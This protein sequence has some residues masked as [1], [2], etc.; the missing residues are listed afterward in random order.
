[1]TQKETV[2]ALL[3]NWLS[4][5]D[6]L[7]KGGGMRLAAVVHQLKKEGHDIESKWNFS[8]EFVIYRL[9]PKQE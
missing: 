5:L 9:K 1:M 7:Q 3:Q 4:A 6:C 2:L 8:H